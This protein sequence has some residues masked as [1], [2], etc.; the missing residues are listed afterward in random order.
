MNI[1]LLFW[2]IFVHC[3]YSPE[4]HE[5]ATC[6]E[7]STYLQAPLESQSK[8]QLNSLQSDNKTLEQPVMATNESLVG[9][10]DS[11]DFPVTNQNL[12]SKRTRSEEVSDEA[13]SAE[14][15]NTTGP[16]KT[17]VVEKDEKGIHAANFVNG[18]NKEDDMKKR[19]DDME[20]WAALLNS[21]AQ[22]GRSS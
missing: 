19:D 21:E 7:V 11:M 2:V 6:K 13:R 20:N 18:D 3:I 8:K 12:T 14:N 15:G 9:N 17:R 10:T 1:L 5:F 22:F 16:V 4:G